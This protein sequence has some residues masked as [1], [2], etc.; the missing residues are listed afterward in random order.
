M[1]KLLALTRKAL[2]PAQA[3]QDKA[4]GLPRPAVHPRTLAPT[5]F[6]VEHQEAIMPTADGKVFGLR[7]WEEQDEDGVGTGQPRVMPKCAI[8]VAECNELA[9]GIVKQKAAPDWDPEK[10]KVEDVAVIEAAAAEME[11]ER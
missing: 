6:M 11:L 10:I 5:G 3:A 2:E 9:A 4:H 7:I 8:D 1:K